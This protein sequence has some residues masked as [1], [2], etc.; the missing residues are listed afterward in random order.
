[1]FENERKEKRIWKEILV[2]LSVVVAAVTLA[3]LTLPGIALDHIC[4]LEE[5]THGEECLSEKTKTLSC[6]EEIHEH[7]E[8]C[9][10]EYGILICGKADFIIHVHS[11]LC[12]DAE[13]NLVCTLPEIAEHY[14]NEE[15]KDENGNLACELTE[16]ITHI[17]SEVCSDENGVLVCELPEVFEHA[18]FIGCYGEPVLDCETAE[19]LHEE[20]CWVYNKVTVCNS[21]E[22]SHTEGCFDAEGSVICEIAEHAHEELCFTEEKTLSCEEEEHTHSDECYVCGE[23]LCEETKVYSHE[24]EASCYDTNGELFCNEYELPVH[25]HEEEKCVEV[26]SGEIVCE[27]K[28]HIHTEECENSK[29]LTEEEQLQVDDVIFLIDI[30]PELSEIEFNFKDLKESGKT[31]E[32]AAYE[33]KIKNSVKA[34][35]DGYNALNDKQ[36]AAVTNY[37]KLPPYAYLIEEDEAVKEV[38]VKINALP[39][40]EE[41]KAAYDALPDETA[42]D[43]STAEQ[44]IKVDEILSLYSALTLEQKAFV[45]NIDKLIALDELLTELTKTGDSISFTGDGYT[46]EITYSPDANLPADTVVTSKEIEEGSKEFK[47]DIKEIAA[48]L[49]FGNL[50]DAQLYDVTL[51]SENKEVQPEVPVEVRFEVKRPKVLNENQVVYGVHFTEEGIEFIPANYELDENGAVIAVTY[52]Q[53]GFSKSGFIF[54]HTPNEDDKGPDDLPVHYALYMNGEW[55][56]VG[57][58]RTGWYGD[59]THKEDWTA[60]KRDFITVDQIASVMGPYFAQVLDKNVEDLT[61][62][63]IKF[64]IENNIFYQRAE[65]AGKTIRFDTSIEQRTVIL[66]GVEQTVDVFPLSGNENKINGYH[67]FYVPN[68]G[69]EKSATFED[70]N[71]FGEFVKPELT[72]QFFSFTVRDMNNVVYS[73]EEEDQIPPMQ[74]VHYG[75][76]ISVTV[77]G[78]YDEEGTPKGWQWVNN[79]GGVVHGITRIYDTN[80]DGV[81]DEEPDDRFGYKDNGDGTATYTFGSYEDGTGILG[82]TTLIPYSTAVEGAEQS[83][84]PGAQLD[85]AVYIDGEWQK[86]GQLNLMYRKEETCMGAPHNGGEDVP[87]WFVTAGQIYTILKDYGFEP[88]EYHPEGDKGHVFT[89]TNGLF[90]NGASNDRVME[91]DAVVKDLGNGTWALGVCDEIENGHTLYYVPGSGDEPKEAVDGVTPNQYAQTDYMNGDRFYSVNVID[92]NQLIYYAEELEYIKIAVYE[93]DDVSISVENAL[94]AQWSVRSESGKYADVRPVNHEGMATFTFTDVRE[95]ID[96]VATAINPNFTV[97]YYSEIN[98][99]VLYDSADKVPAGETAIEIIDTS[100]GNL[101][102]NKGPWKSTYIALRDTGRDIKQST[103]WSDVFTVE[104]EKKYT[105]IYSDNEFEFVRAYQ[106][107]NIDKLYTNDSYVIDSVYILKPGYDPDAEKDNT[108]AWWIYMADANGANINFTNNAYEEFAPKEEGIVQPN[109]QDYTI[110]ITEGMV[111]RLNYKVDTGDFNAPTTFHDYDVTTNGSTGR[112]N[113]EAKKKDVGINTSNN[114]SGTGTRYGFGNDNHNTTIGD[115][116]WKDPNGVTNTPNM[117]NRNAGFKF[118]TF[119]I[120]KGFDPSTY[121]VTWNDGL[122]GPKI[123][124]TSHTGVTG[125]YTYNNGSLTF[126]REGDV[127]T[128]TAANSGA[129][130]RTSLEELFHPSSNAT[131]YTN[132]YT[133]NFWVL[134]NAPAANRKDPIVGSA[135]NTNGFEIADDKTDHNYFFGMNFQIKFSLTADYIGPIEYLFFGDDDMWV[136][137]TDESGKQTL[138]CDIGGV[139]SAVGEYVNLRDYLPLGSEGRYTLNFFY[140]ERGAS[141]STCWMSFTLPS[142]TSVNLEEDVADI[143][144]TK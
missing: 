103:A 24:H 48:Q 115:D 15:C 33:L 20:A 64:Q 126:A 92:D 125:K 8:E 120:V 117:A 112:G 102:N 97:Q 137:L 69:C 51:L 105:K 26:T 53:S 91:V 44:I 4:G 37:E 130:S 143:E 79:T 11:E 124:G 66:D 65:E 74:I 25:E 141:G 132:I 116:T 35:F 18:H 83:T 95:T 5:H 119:G 7:T 142:V 16:G 36:K 32:L 138:I 54:V 98:R 63:E 68:N 118:C 39:T 90:D 56:V 73:L 34:A 107:Y 77:K 128:L 78:N 85:I 87:Y 31:E 84:A 108:E 121:Q 28:E 104:S 70:S 89:H 59:Y 14:H 12:Y 10:N 50:I 2:V 22:H 19:H 144:V 133:N 52:E 86:V 40:A 93:G 9:Y 1:M 75:N 123:F 60:E 88:I 111:I 67:L 110:L 96:L 47:D 29:P 41:Y 76:P 82:R 30:L 136:F 80:K 101:P 135:N 72:R 81:F 62:E 42:K 139:H 13:S 27:L 45:T 106:W 134:D 21:E 17:H 49:T 71:T 46:A 122:R 131:P 114:Y 58:T 57:S 109:T 55:Y 113:G 99:Y 6:K 61:D 140:T 3:A 23:L 129:G 38:I 127:Y 94:E 100:G 43:E